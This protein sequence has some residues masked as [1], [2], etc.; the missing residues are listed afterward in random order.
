MESGTERQEGAQPK[1]RVKGKKKLVVAGVLVAIVVVAGG[2]LFVWH[3]QPSFCAAICHT[4]MD[5]YLV[6]YEQTAG[7]SGTDKYGESVADTSSMLAVTHRASSSEGGADAACLDCHVP[8][9]GEQVSEGLNWVSGNY[10]YPLEERTLSDLVAARG[11]ED[12]ATFCLNES[13]HNL[14]RDDLE[15]LTADMNRNPHSAYHDTQECSDCHKA[16]R[17][18]VN[19]CASCH[20]DADT[21]D[22]WAKP[23]ASSRTGGAL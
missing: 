19:D 20:P 9:I 12:E 7:E 3:E 2:G 6:T 5:E 17:A 21:P 10:V 1:K 16:H 11:L 14:T 4:P 8:T 23:N 18:S 15:S 22:S 13:C